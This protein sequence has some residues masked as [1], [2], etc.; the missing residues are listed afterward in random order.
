MTGVLA[1]VG[2]LCK[3][4][5][6]TSL[7]VCAAWDLILHR[8]HLRRLLSGKAQLRH[9]TP[10]L[11]RLLWLTATGAGILCV[12]LWL[13]RGMAPVFSDQDNPA[14]FSPSLL[15]R[16]LTF[17]YLPA[18][19]AWLLLCPWRLSHDWQM[20]SIPLIN[21]LTDVRNLASLLLYTSLFLTVRSGCL[22]KGVEGRAVLLGVALLVLPFL[23]ATNLLFTVGFVVAERILYI[24]SLG[25]AVLLGVGLSRVG[26]LRAPCLLLLLLI[27]S[28]R[29]LQRN[30]DW[31]SRESLFSAGLRTLPHNAKMHYNYGNLQKDLGDPDLAKFHYSEAIRYLQE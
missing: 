12:R 17:A 5:A 18:F 8:K 14:S 29:T 16:V 11:R 28:C 1:G 25:Y 26:R 15:T 2:T 22:T 9:L 30:R 6:L 3:E 20:G 23:P 21:S 24:P 13:L 4:H 31:D 27:F 19:N 7:L 10:L